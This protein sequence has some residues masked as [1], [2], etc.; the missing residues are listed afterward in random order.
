MRKVSDFTG[1]SEVPPKRI[2]VVDDAPD[3]AD[4]IQSALRALG[5][6]V[7]TVTNPDEALIQYGPGKYDLVIADYS[8]PRMNGVEL[9]EAI[10]HR[11]QDQLIM[12]LTAYAFSIASQHQ[13]PLPVN[14]V[15]MKPASMKDLQDALVS[16]F[17]AA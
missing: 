2:L 5:H 7:D 11:S 1:V 3:V 13:A 8:M 15:L 17:P 6:K 4:T 9:A 14:K 16:L 12:M 10:R